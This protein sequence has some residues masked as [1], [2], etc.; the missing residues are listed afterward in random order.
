M[1]KQDRILKYL[2]ET[3][4]GE[5]KIQFENEL[6]SSLEL[7]S[8]FDK[9]SASIRSLKHDTE[10]RTS[11]KYFINLLPK[12]REKIDEKYKRRINANRKTILAL[13]LITIITFLF[14]FNTKLTINS[15]ENPEQLNGVYD[16]SIADDS[17][18]NDFL[19]EYYSE[20]PYTIEIDLFSDENYF[21]PA[22]EDMEQYIYNNT[23]EFIPFFEVST[24]GEEMDEVIRVL[25]DKKIL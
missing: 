20:A 14:L 10:V 1:N 23:T 22:V 2:S 6:K 25:S 24:S 21:L 8:E 16:I 17:I 18:M 19:D 11:D 3:M 9:I 13:G 15:D 4:Q 7:R 5:E 12:V